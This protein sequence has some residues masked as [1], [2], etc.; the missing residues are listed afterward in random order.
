MRGGGDG[1][2][3]GGCCGYR[4]RR[5]R[6]RQRRPRMLIQSI[7]VQLPRAIFS[8][9]T[10]VTVPSHCAQASKLLLTSY[11]KNG[12]S[13]D[14]RLHY[15]VV[16]Q[17]LCSLF[18]YNSHCTWAVRLSEESHIFAESVTSSSEWILA[19]ISSKNEQYSA[20][21]HITFDTRMACMCSK[22]FQKAVAST[23]N[24]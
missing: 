20:N 19:R 14:R 23:L 15:K 8:E 9:M 13:S 7:L 12:K 18:H 1:G 6:R 5:I 24:R 2:G 3:N 21:S 16:S 4:R 10:D 22:V 11:G 17:A